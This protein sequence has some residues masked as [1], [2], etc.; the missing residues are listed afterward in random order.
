M[1]RD[2]GTGVAAV[3]VLV[4]DGRE[5]ERASCSRTEGGSWD[6]QQHADLTDAER[7]PATQVV[8]ADPMQLTHILHKMQPRNVGRAGRT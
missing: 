5:Q 1:G 4:A 2:V 3:A 8:G 7:V 6:G